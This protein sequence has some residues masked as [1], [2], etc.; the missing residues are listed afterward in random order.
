[1]IS[2]RI[3][4]SEFTVACVIIIIKQKPICKAMEMCS[5]PSHSLSSLNTC[6]MFTSI[7]EEADLQ[8]AI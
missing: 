4:L 5:S 3:G 1:M 6:Q 8:T 7:F 2:Q